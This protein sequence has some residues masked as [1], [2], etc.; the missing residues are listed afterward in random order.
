[1]RELTE[2][3][4][5]LESMAAAG[6]ALAESRFGLPR[7]RDDLVR[8]YDDVLRA[9]RPAPS[10]AGPTEIP[11]PRDAAGMVAAPVA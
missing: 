8:L 6:R 11:A 1:M 4:H 3:P 9:P 10:T 7:F 2:R 5:R